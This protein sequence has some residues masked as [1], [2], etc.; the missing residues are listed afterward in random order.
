MK[1]YYVELQGHSKNWST[2]Y[3]LAENSNEAYAKVRG[4]LDA[5]D[6]DFSAHRELKRV[7]LIA[8]AKDYPDCG[9]KLYID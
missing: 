9:V 4:Y 5:K 6:I 3:V 2:A 8:E 1:L 7:T